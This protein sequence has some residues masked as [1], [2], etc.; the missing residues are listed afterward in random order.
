MQTITILVEDN[1]TIRD[2][3][4]PTMAEEANVQVVAIAETARR[5]SPPS[6]ETAP[7]D[8]WRL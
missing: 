8:S 6:P 7:N 3:L 1:K 5:R 4:I 2:Q